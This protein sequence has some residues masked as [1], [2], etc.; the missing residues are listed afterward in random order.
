METDVQV[1]EATGN[2]LN[3]TTFAS[4]IATAFANNTGG[5]WNFDGA[6]FAV[7]GGEMITLNYGTSATNS[8]VLTLSGSEVNQNSGIGQP[9]SGST[10]LGFVDTG[11]RTFT[12]DTPLLTVGYFNLDRE[13]AGRNPRLTVT[14]QDT[15]TASTSGANADNVFFH[16]L[17]GTASNPIV[18]FAFSQDNFV[19][20]DDLGFIAVPEPTSALLVGLGFLGFVARRRR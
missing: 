7:N 4:N 3:V 16:G 5:V 15:T 6:P 2:S 11:T 8:L 9:T 13:A 20:Y 18:S 17:S 14:Y 19:V 10:S 12:P 1:N